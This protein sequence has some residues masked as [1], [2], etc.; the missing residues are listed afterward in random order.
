MTKFMTKF[1]G[2]FDLDG[3]KFAAYFKSHLQLK[4]PPPETG[5]ISCCFPIRVYKLYA[6]DNN[7][8]KLYVIISLKRPKCKILFQIIDGLF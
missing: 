3:A 6:S 7:D 1:G 2:L 4:F 5:W 8:E